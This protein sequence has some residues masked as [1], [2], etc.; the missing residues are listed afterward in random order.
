MFPVK[1]KKKK[2]QYVTDECLFDF[3][4]F[5]LERPNVN[6][7]SMSC[8]NEDCAES[9]FSPHHSKSTVVWFLWWA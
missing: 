8:L 9:P 1:K 7:K 4:F 6:G 2:K 3:F 5:L